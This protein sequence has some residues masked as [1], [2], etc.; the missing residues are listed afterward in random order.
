MQDVPLEDFVQMVVAI[1]LKH[2]LDLVGA[3]LDKFD[4]CHVAVE[5][6]KDAIVPEVDDA[7]VMSCHVA[8]DREGVGVILRKVNAA[9][10]MEGKP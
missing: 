8:Y 5:R 2:L 9:P 6:A 3:K 10:P 7:V 1:D 4:N